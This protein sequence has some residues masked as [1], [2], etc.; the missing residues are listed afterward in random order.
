MYRGWL[1]AL[2]VEEEVVADAEWLSLVVDEEDLLELAIEEGP[3]LPCLSLS[4][5]RPIF[6]ATL[7]LEEKEA[8][9]EFSSSASSLK[10][11]FMLNFITFT[12]RNNP[13]NSVFFYFRPRVTSVA[14]MTFKA[15]SSKLIL[16]FVFD[17]CV[18]CHFRL[19]RENISK[20]GMKSVKNRLLRFPLVF[21]FELQWSRR[22]FHASYS[23]HLSCTILC[24]TQALKDNLTSPCEFFTTMYLLLS[25]ISSVRPWWGW[26]LLAPE[27]I[28]THNTWSTEQF[29]MNIS[30]LKS[31]QGCTLGL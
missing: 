16:F 21:F 10:T 28:L 14:L 8:S 29:V 11:D 7:V 1:L 19:L 6:E 23:M 2:I 12:P 24:I 17:V 31:T 5:P 26:V 3:L 4:I 9:F 25:I 13:N 20:L 15:M 30:L 22:E 27:P 18:I